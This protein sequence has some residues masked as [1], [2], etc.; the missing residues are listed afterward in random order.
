[1]IKRTPCRKVA[2]C[3]VIPIL[4]IVVFTPDNVVKTI[5]LVHLIEVEC[6]AEVDI[7]KGDEAVEFMR[8]WPA[9]SVI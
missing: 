9:L 4:E 5:P 3:I 2:V 8:L 7:A 1:M 6:R